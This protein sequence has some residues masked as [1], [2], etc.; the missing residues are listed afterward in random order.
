M[1]CY[2]NDSKEVTMIKN[3]K[4][5][6]QKTQDQAFILSASECI[7]CKILYAV[8]AYIQNILKN[9]NIQVGMWETDHDIS[10]IDQPFEIDCKTKYHIT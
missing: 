5:H 6:Y 4:R 9:K 3:G 1:C 2:A 7:K 10:K 8:Q